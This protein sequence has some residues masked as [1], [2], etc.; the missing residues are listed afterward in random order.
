ME[1]KIEVQDEVAAELRYLVELH[2]QYEAANPQES[3]E[4]LL[5]YAAEAIAD[6][7]R[8]PGAWER[9]LLDMMGLTAECPEHE[10][11]RSEYG[12]PKA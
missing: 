2:S 11:Y 6:G 10:T 5:S 8:R 4:S 3:I 9:Q 12:K 7:S 1:I